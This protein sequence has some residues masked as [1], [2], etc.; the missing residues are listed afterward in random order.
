MVS[1]PPRRGN[2]PAPLAEL[3][4]ASVMRVYVSE[5]GRDFCGSVLKRWVDSGYISQLYHFNTLSAFMRR[6]IVTWI[7]IEM[8]RESAAPLAQLGPRT[9]A[10]DSTGFTT[11]S[12]SLWYDAKFGR[13][14]KRDYMKLH[15]AVD[16][17]NHVITEAVVTERNGDDTRRLPRLLKGTKQRIEVAEVTADKAYAGRPNYDAIQEA[18]ATPLIPRRGRMSG[19]GNALM[20]QMFHAFHAWKRHRAFDPVAA[21]YF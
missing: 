17:Q 9:I 5:S 21:S 11:S 19:K 7:L 8:I 1:A 2:Q 6:R 20:R 15:I 18:G 13:T 16:A 12:S 3:L 10:V 4:F 14:A